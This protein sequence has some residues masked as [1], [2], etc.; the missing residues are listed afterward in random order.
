MR[1]SNR[2]K[3]GGKLQRD[4]GEIEPS[5]IDSRN[6]A[7]GLAANQLELAKQFTQFFSTQ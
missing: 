4:G 2:R 6:L 1:K 7:R 3:E 5:K